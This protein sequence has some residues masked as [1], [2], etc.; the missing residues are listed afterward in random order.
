MNKSIKKGLH[1][2]LI[3]ASLF[4]GY[5][6]VKSI[7]DPIDFQKQKAKRDNVLRERLLN[8]RKAQITYRDA[9]KGFCKDIDELVSFVLSDS[10]KAIKQIGDENDTS[11]VVVKEIIWSKVSHEIFP[12]KTEEEIKELKFVPF[13]DNQNVIEM[14][15]GVIEKS[16]IQVPVFEAKVRADVLYNGLDD[17]FYDHRHYIQVGSMEDAN[18]N[19]NWQ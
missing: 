14:S 9:K 10:I 11:V 12:K 4:L 18:I 5:Q 6:I 3:V 13:T 15:A 8:I 1:L 19:G 17:R 16:R 2:L 7:K